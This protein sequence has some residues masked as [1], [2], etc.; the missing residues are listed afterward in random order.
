MA[1]CSFVGHPV[2]PEV[3]AGWG[4]EA[5]CSAF[6]LM[7]GSEMVGYGELWVPDDE[8][9]VELARLIV[10]PHRRN[11]GYGRQLAEALV[12]EASAIAGDVFLRVRPENLGAQRVYSTAGFQ[13]VDA[14]L[15]AE[16][17]AEQPVDY[18]WMRAIEPGGTVRP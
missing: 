17:N 2:P 5:G 13:R 14:D 16:W 10:A 3:V 12:D 7:D 6:T 1:W 9:E 4:T 15:E 8:S 11:R 18:V